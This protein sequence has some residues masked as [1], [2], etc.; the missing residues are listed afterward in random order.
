MPAFF[1]DRPVFAWVIA[2]VIALAGAVA[3]PQLPTERYPA[4]APPSISIYATYPGASPQTISDGVISLIERELS[5]VRNLLY[6]ES[7]TDTSG[8]ATITVTFKP[9][10]NPDLA[11]VDVQNRLKTVEPRL[12]QAVRQ[13]G[14][15]VEAAASGFLLL[16]DI[17]APGGAYDE[18]TL[19]DYAVRNVADELKRVP[20]V[21]RVQLFATERAMRIWID[22][23]K[24]SA[25]GITFGDVTTAIA[26]QNVQI[27]PGALGAEPATAGQRVTVPLEVDGRLRTPEEFRAIVLRAHP[28]GSTL[29]LGAVAQVELGAQSYAFATRSNGKPVATLAV[30]LA[31]GA[32]AVTTSSAIAARMTE[33]AKAMP[34]GMGFSIPFDTAP[35]VRVSIEKVLVTLLEAM[36]L[37]FL[38]MF[39]FLQN[40]RCTLIP[41]IVAPI[42]LLGT[43]AVMLAAGYSINVLTM[44]GMVLAIGIIVDDAIVVVETVER[45][46][47]QEGLAPREATLRAM[48]EMS[49]AVVGITLVLSAVFVPMALAGG[50]VGVIYRQF[51]LTMAVSILLSA[52]LALTLTPALCATMLRPVREHGEKRGVFG[53]FDRCFAGLTRGYARGVARLVGRPWRMMAGFAVIVMLLGLAFARLPSAFLP[54]EDQGYFLTSIQ[55]PPDATA[56]RTREAVET[57]ERHNATRPSVRHTESIM[58]FGFSGSGP[59]AA[60][61]Y[62]ILTDWNARQGASAADEVA[63]ANAAARSVREGSIVSMLPPAIDGLG[64]TSGFALRLEDRAGRGPVALAAAKDRLLAAAAASPVL[65]DIYEEGLPPGNRIRLHVDRLKAQVLGVSFADIADTLS[66]AMGSSYV[67]D[68]TNLGRVQQVI[69]QADAAARMTLDDIL[70]LEVRNAAGR[71]VQL[72]ELAAPAWESGPLQLVRYNGYPAARITGAAAPGRSS[73]EAMREMERL[74]R[75]LPPGFAVTWTGQSLQEQEAGAQAPLLLTLSMLVVFLVLAALYESWSVPLAVMLVVPLGLIGAVAAVMLRDMPND[76]LFTVGLVTIIGLSAKNAILIVEFARAARARGLDPA[77]AAVEAAQLRLRPIVMTSLAFTLG[78]VPLMVASGAGS[79]TQQSIGT[80]VFG[81]MIS[82]TVL[83][84]LFVPVF[85][86][87]VTKLA[88]RLAGRVGR[89]A[90]AEPLTGPAGPG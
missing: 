64:T 82:A 73:G 36:A 63:R 17:I 40:V 13:L 81:G 35:F 67:N 3:I 39:V 4:I 31:P 74:A 28:D 65:T 10:T 29:T 11:Q 86:V 83:A 23:V 2:I 70:G 34:E 44:F 61:I 26:Q 75:Q 60:M 32:N 46:M 59:N 21:G 38:V 77:Q 54:E 79:E 19:G 42:A 30:Q 58:G 51:V 25:H 24:L 52:F 49:G 47:A 1:I 20:G 53:W 48:G 33:L 76:V 27:A 87:V 80:G 8:T 43:F 85:F 12:P 57:M 56:N 78:I 62:T 14:L 18:V 6:F 9:G 45:L 16:V 88:E 71:S 7:A 5:S 15:T 66:A 55:L 68:F 84:V 41:A 90:A 22:P 50:S 89:G 72:S 37:V 69:V